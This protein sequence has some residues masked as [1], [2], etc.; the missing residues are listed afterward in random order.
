M[1]MLIFFLWMMQLP[2]ADDVELDAIAHMTEGF[3]GAD[4]Q[5]LLSD[6]Q[7]EAVHEL[8]A[9]ADNKEPGKKPVIADAL[10]KSVASKARP[11]VSD[12]EKER[13]FYIYNQFLDSKKSTAQVFLRPPPPIYHIQSCMHFLIALFANKEFHFAV[14]GCKRQKGNPGI[15]NNRPCLTP[16]SLRI[17][18]NFVFYWFLILPPNIHNDWPCKLTAT[19]HCVPN[20]TLL[21]H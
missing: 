12:A 1:V 21:M 4:L 9:I 8:L 5:A 18:I 6:A 19:H 15:A 17:T 7:L 14:K 3:S 2:L 20:K 11:S 13:L 10:L 16:S